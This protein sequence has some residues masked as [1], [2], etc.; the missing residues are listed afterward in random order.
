MSAGRVIIVR[1]TTPDGKTLAQVFEIGDT[2]LEVITA[3]LDRFNALPPVKALG[4]VR[5]IAKANL[6]AGPATSFADVGDVL[7]GVE[8][9]ALD[10][11]GPWVR[12]GL[13]AWIKTGPLAEWVERYAD[14]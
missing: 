5:T 10:E 11:V 4:R 12:V 6:W 2:N 1:P 7:K 13:N 8:F 3:F 14:Q 9:Y